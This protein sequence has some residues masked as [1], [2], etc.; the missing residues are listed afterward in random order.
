MNR[1]M[2]GGKTTKREVSEDV[3]FLYA[4]AE[5]LFTY[6]Q[7]HTQYLSSINTDDNPIR[8]LDAC[9]GEEKNLGRAIASVNGFTDVT[10]IDIK[11]GHNIFDVNDKFDVIV[12]NPPWNLKTSLPVYKHLINNCMADDGILFFVINIVFCYQGSDRAEELKYQ[13]FYFFPRWVFKH[14]GRP[15]LD[16]GVMVYDKSGVLH[17]KAGQLT[18]YIPLR[19]HY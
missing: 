12:C 6:L 13:K 16:C 19:R 17:Q 3:E 14:T 18:P 1:R 2:G 8:V 9:C 10:Y 7:P 4:N 5:E 15:L 11:N